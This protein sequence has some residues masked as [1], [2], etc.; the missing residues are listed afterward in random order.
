MKRPASAI[1]KMTPLSLSLSL[2]LARNWESRWREKAKRERPLLLRL[3]MTHKC[4]AMLWRRHYDTTTYKYFF[5]H[6][7]YIL[8]LPEMF[9]FQKS[10]LSNSINKWQDRKPKTV[11]CYICSNNCAVEGTFLS[12]HKGYWV[13][14]DPFTVWLPHFTCTPLPCSVHH[15]YGATTRVGMHYD[16]WQC[17][18][19]CKNAGCIC[20]MLSCDLSHTVQQQVSCKKKWLITSIGASTLFFC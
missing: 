3:S 17:V 1:Q 15:L 14:F 8:K 19:E 7:K 6:Q 9:I 5:Y 16:D 20:E 2:S 12:R 18:C 10:Q 11:N 4:D 13:T